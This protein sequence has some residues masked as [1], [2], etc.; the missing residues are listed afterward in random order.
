MVAHKRLSKLLIPQVSLSAVFIF[1]SA[2]LGLKRSNGD[3]CFKI[4]LLTTPAAF[5][6]KD[7][8]KKIG[9]IKYSCDETVFDDIFI[10]YAHTERNIDIARLLLL[11]YWG[12][13]SAFF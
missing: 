7:G 3:I 2:E 6:C 10:S 9:T 8:I 4:S 1:K 11:E 12:I 13:G 5:R